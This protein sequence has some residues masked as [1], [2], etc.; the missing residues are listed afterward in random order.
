MIGVNL[1]NIRFS[2]LDVD[3]RATDIMAFS[4]I[5]FLD[6]GTPKWIYPTKTQH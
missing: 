5:N 1:V 4:N 3:A 6:F 2:D